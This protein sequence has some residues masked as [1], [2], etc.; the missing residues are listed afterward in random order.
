MTY[1]SY[2]NNYSTSN[3]CTSSTNTNTST[4][5]YSPYGTCSY[6]SPFN[7]TGFFNYNNSFSDIFSFLTGQVS[8]STNTSVSTQCDST[9]SSTSTTSYTKDGSYSK[10]GTTTSSTPLPAGT[11]TVYY[12]ANNAD[13]DVVQIRNSNGTWQP[14][15]TGTEMGAIN[16]SDIRV[17]NQTQ[18]TYVYGN[19][20]GAKISTNADGSVSITF[21]DRYGTCKND[22][23]Y[24]DVVV[25]I[26]TS[27]SSS[28]SDT[29][30]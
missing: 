3:S 9:T 16:S 26:S 22:K 20:S 13:K 2:S 24:N 5:T 21:E 29:T 27:D 23:D 6:T 8:G 7:Y 14:L 30:S 1:Y 12:D 25:T 19:G 28:F 10:C 18:N 4:T 17:Y 11:A 15:T